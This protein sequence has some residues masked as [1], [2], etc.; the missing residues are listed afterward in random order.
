M[1]TKNQLISDII[2]RV[3]K[4]K[5][6]DDFELEPSQVAFWINLVRDKILK[7]YLDSKIG[8]NLGI[9]DYFVVKE[10]C[11]A[12]NEESEPCIDDDKERLYIKLKKEPLNILKDAAI[13]RIITNEGSYVKKAK[14]TTID[15][16]NN[17]EFGKPTEDNVVYYRDG[18]QKIII[19]GIPRAMKDEIEFF[20]WYMPKEDLLCMSDDEEVTIPGEFLPDLL[21]EVEKL[22]R[23]QMY[24]TG[25]VTNDGTDDLPDRPDIVN[26]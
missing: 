17:L 8:N 6:A 3:T 4:G 7:T 22:A 19:E 16:V 12:L 24:G 18:A 23:R 9:E 1:A 5:P 11:K 2:L 14:I 20:V 25:D 10:P 15:W 13:V 21:D 26:G